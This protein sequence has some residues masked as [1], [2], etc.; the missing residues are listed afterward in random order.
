MTKLEMY[1]IDKIRADYKKEDK[2][3]TF[4]G[5]DDEMLAEYYFEFAHGALTKETILDVIYEAVEELG[6]RTVNV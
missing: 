3:G 6:I 2:F 5:Y 4:A 1:L